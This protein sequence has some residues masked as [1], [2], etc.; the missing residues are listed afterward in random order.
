MTDTTTSSATSAFDTTLA[1]L[2]IARTTTAPTVQTAAA[3]STLTQADF[4]QLLTAQMQNQDPFNPLDNT[5]MVAQMAQFSQLSA[6]TDMSTTLTAIA[7]KLGAVSPT[8]AMAYI[9][10]TVLTAGNTAYGRSAGGIAGAIQLGGAASDVNVTIS[11]ASGN[12]LHTAELGAQAAGTV[13]YD[14]NGTVDSTGAAAGTGPFTVQ[15]SAN[16]AGTPVTA[17]NLVWAPVE[18]VSTASGSTVLTVPGVGTVPV[19]AI[20]QIGE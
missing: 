16:N 8:D 20:Q 14:W 5:E 9:G 3:S 17:T 13:N 4:L 18:S 12:I 19:S 10:K 6:T 15:V 2:G 7:N 11:D 1:N